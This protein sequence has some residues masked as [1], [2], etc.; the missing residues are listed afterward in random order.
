MIKYIFWDFDGVLCDSKDICFKVHNKLQE[1]YKTLPIINDSFDY[2]KLMN[3]GYDNSLEKHLSKE[4]KDNYLFE[5][6]ELMYSK[7]DEFKL[8][9]KVIEF[10]KNRKIP[11]IIITA[12]YEKLVN[13]VLY[14]NGYSKDMFLDILG[15]E[16][17]NGK[18]E[19]FNYICKKLD[20]N[21]SEIIY[22]GDTLNDVDFCNKVGI[23]I[24]CVGYGY[25]PK[26]IFATEDFLKLC[27]N[28]EELIEY[29]I[30]VTKSEMEIK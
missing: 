24:V 16:T 5:H 22:I 9:T 1:K 4:Q 19:R 15:R 17:K 3:A 12:T 13:D 21:K 27:N 14:N 18:V 30:N 7:R 2:A 11:S 23:N 10:I 26:E 20:I 8:F 6:R 28:Q 29:L 25:S